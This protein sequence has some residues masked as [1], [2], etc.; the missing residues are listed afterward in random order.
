MLV[1]LKLALFI[2]LLGGCAYPEN[3]PSFP[4]RAEIV[5]SENGVYQLREVSFQTLTNL[6]HMEGSI[7]QLQGGAS[8]NVSADVAEIINSDEPDNIY[9]ERGKAVNLDYIVQDDLV[10]PKNFKSMEMLGL[11]YSYERTLLYW[12]D[13]MG[14]NFSQVGYPSVYY[15]P[16][17]TASDDGQ[18]TEVVL[19][20]N[21]A[22]LSGAKDFWFFKTSRM[23][24]LPVKMNFGVIAH[25]FGHFI[26]DL[27]FAEFNP[28]F[29]EA[30][31]SGSANQL[32][33]INEGL[34]DYFSFMVTGSVEE[35]GASL[36]ELAEFRKMPV[37]WTLSELGQSA[38]E[39]AFYCKGSILASALHEI[40]TTTSSS[41]EEVGEAI[42]TALPLFRD[43]WR[44]YS[45]SALFDYDRFL[46]RLIEV[47]DDTKKTEYCQI[48][49]KWFNTDFFRGRLQC[50]S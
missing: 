16:S 50:E 29:Y 44:E 43:D 35:F 21:A 13:V 47:V 7:A 15:N 19:A 36:D 1:K 27:Y 49:L 24:K 6:Q 4:I 39:G 3:E 20:L 12:Q 2:L 25:E 14:I 18:K 38:C 11:Y 23:E 28:G 9:R 26:F 37:A 33:G 40:A 42:L 41:A 22:Y 34:A 17:F 5:S 30:E 31:Y 48:F 45:N 32:S 46:N 10:I 8:L